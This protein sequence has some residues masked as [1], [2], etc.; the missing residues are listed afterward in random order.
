MFS[1]QPHFDG[2]RGEEL[3]LS[4]ERGAGHGHSHDQK[5]GGEGKREHCERSAVR[6]AVEARYR[7]DEHDE[8]GESDQAERGVRR[9]A[10]DGAF[11]ADEK[12]EAENEQHVAGD[13]ADK[14][15]PHYVGQAV[16]HG[17]DRDDELWRVPER[18][19]QEAADP[20]TGVTG[21]V[22]G[23]LTDRPR[24]GNEGCG[25][26]YE[27]RQIAGCIEPIENDHERPEQQQR[28]KPASLSERPG[29]QTQR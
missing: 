9:Q 18:R 5:Q 6:V 26:E 25:G 19:V 14:R 22:V 24:E 13:R 28:E 20:R 27:Q 11:S 15:C 7:G 21:E 1:G 23:R 3:S 4:P 12:R 10:I 16:G 8:G 29:R 2:S 17:D